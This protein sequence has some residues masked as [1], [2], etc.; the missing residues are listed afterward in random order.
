MNPRQIPLMDG[1][2]K[3]QC[4]ERYGAILPEEMGLKDPDN[5]VP[6][7]LHWYA[8]RDGKGYFVRT[9]RKSK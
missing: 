9:E 5:E 1:P 3:G 7:V 2:L 8:L 4:H 6:G